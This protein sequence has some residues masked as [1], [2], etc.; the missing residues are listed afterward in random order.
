M[1][2]A[3]IPQNAPICAQGDAS[4]RCPQNRPN[5]M[6]SANIDGVHVLGGGALSERVSGV[7]LLFVGFL[8]QDSRNL[9]GR[10]E[11]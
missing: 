6:T 2:A 11:Q 9:G 10:H 1:A 4:Y 5:S 7:L 3:S 8:L